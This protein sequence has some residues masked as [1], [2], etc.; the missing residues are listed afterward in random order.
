[1]D[2]SSPQTDGA[3]EGR[4]AFPMPAPTGWQRFIAWVVMIAL[5]GLGVLL[6]ATGLIV[7]GIIVLAAF[8]IA[9]ARSLWR[10]IRGE[11]AAGRENVRVIVRR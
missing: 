4:A 3:P 8:A 6:L 2:D 11:N 5:L 10:R 7:G 9:G 1:M